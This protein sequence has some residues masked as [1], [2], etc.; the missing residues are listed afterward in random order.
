MKESASNL[1]RDS[2]D[3]TATWAMIP[4]PASLRSDGVAD[5]TGIRTFD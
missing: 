2:V 5:F 1:M 4:A 3:Q